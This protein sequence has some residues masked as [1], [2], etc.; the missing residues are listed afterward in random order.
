MA[1]CR[2][3]LSWPIPLADTLAD[4]WSRGAPWLVA[5]YLLARREAIVKSTGSGFTYGWFA[6]VF[7]GLVWWLGF[8]A[9]VVLSLL[10]RGTTSP[11]FWSSL[12][13]AG[14]SQCW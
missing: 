13:S 1:L 7:M 6:C 9:F 11:S 3:E 10:D 2:S 8:L 14:R 5:T 12:L 4:I